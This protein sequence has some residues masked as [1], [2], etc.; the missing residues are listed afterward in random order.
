MADIPPNDTVAPSHTADANGNVV[1][2]LSLVEG[3]SMP[4]ADQDPGSP[5]HR[6]PL[7][8][9]AEVAT[10]PDV[11]D[12]Y[13]EGKACV[14]LVTSVKHGSAVGGKSTKQFERSNY[15]LTSVA[16]KRQKIATMAPYDRL[17][18][19]ADLVNPGKMFALTFAYPI[20][21]KRSFFHVKGP[22]VGS[23]IYIGEP[24]HSRDHIGSNVP[25]IKSSWKYIPV[26]LRG[27]HVRLENIVPAVPLA[28]P[29]GSGEQRYYALHGIAV[30][31]SGFRLATEDVSCN[32]KFC[33]RQFKA[34]QNVA[35]GCWTHG[36]SSES[37]VCE[38]NVNLNVNRPK[39]MSRHADGTDHNRGILI[40]DFRSL[41]LTEFLFANLSDFAKQEQEAIE[42][43][44]PAMRRQVNAMVD[45][46]N[47][48]GGWT[49]VGWFKKGEVK[50]MAAASD[51]VKVES[52]EVKMH[53]SLLTPTNLDL[54]YL[55]STNIK[56][57]QLR[58]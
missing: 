19:C 36:L 21:G 53:L 46:V 52:D 5:Y 28:I 9:A 48:N 35:C 57:L 45:Y 16:T 41:R 3:Y 54:A 26:S 55:R 1:I 49:V 15:T 37:V 30:T 18:M 7:L 8:I 17:V 34:I 27:S 43:Q 14:G 39:G 23:I 31:I 40:Q 6:P 33:D 51:D 22:G 32:G 25:I 20:D 58:K 12:E 11:M 4:W 47:T 24:K 2:P 13:L 50:D 38:C 56:E 10:R 42:L 29:P 44:T